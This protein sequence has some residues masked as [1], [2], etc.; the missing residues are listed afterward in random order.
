MR[1]PFWS[2]HELTPSHPSHHTPSLH[3]YG[4]GD[5]RGT[6]RI[7]MHVEFPSNMPG[8]REHGRQGRITIETA[9]RDLVPHS[10]KTFLEVVKGWQHRG[11]LWA[12][13]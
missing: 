13:A 7:E 10:V 8:N 1:K 6:Y 11:V 5:S 12:W 9:P 3:R 4:P 2:K